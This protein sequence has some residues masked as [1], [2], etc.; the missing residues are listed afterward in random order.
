MDD[1]L[2]L[3][4]PIDYNLLEDVSGN[5]GNFSPDENQEA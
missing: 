5:K 4:W 2:A 1:T 3:L